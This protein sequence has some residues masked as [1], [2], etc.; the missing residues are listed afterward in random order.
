MKDL[1][2]ESRIKRFLTS[3]KTLICK[4]H[5]YTYC[6]LSR[7][8]LAMKRNNQTNMN[9]QNYISLHPFKFVSIASFALHRD[10]VNSFDL[11]RTA[12]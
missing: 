1:K 10:N 4:H 11:S 7:V 2:E 12:D 9:Y 3:Q 8:N 6:H 5:T